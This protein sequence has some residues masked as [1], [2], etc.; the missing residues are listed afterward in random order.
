MDIKEALK[1]AEAVIYDKEKRH[2]ND[3]EVDILQGSWEGETYNEIAENSKY[4]VNYLKGDIGH[5]FWKL[6]SE[7]LGE[8]V[9]KRNFRAALER[10]RSRFLIGNSMQLQLEEARPSQKLVSDLYV[11]RP[12]LNLAVTKR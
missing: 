10:S 11:E 3:A 12:R 6:L 9:S 5:K 7:A 1:I 4:E 2:L 8:Q